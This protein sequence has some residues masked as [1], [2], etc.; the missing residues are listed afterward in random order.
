MAHKEVVSTM[1][2]FLRDEEVRQVVTMEDML[3]AIPAWNRPAR[4]D[5]HCEV[6]DTLVALERFGE[7]DAG[8]DAAATEVVSSCERLA[9]DDRVLAEAS[10]WVE[11]DDTVCTISPIICSK[12]RVMVSTRRPRSILASASVASQRHSSLTVP[13]TIDHRIHESTST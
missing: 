10:S 8:E 9:V 11:A 5:G 13:V 1:A 6:A 4:V 7:A 12:L 3:E 2:L